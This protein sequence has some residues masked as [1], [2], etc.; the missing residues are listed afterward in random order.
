MVVVDKLEV[1]DD[2]KRLR[3]SIV[4]AMNQG[5]GIMMVLDVEENT[6]KFFSRQLML[7]LIHI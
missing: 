1:G 4:T 6:G 5:K 3:E 2:R 7:S